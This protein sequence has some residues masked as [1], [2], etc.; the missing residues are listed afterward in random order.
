MRRLPF[1]AQMGGT[2][3]RS[4]RISLLNWFVARDMTAVWG[5][6]SLPWQTGAFFTVQGAPYPVEVAPFRNPHAARNG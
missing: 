2:A 4:G 1:P 5:H 3:R 6:F